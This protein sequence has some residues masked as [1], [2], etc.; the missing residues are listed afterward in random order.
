M[1]GSSEDL[2]ARYRRGASS[3]IESTPEETPEQTEEV[4][5]PVET[6]EVETPE[7]EPEIPEP[8]TEE[9]PEE[10]APAAAKPP[11]T[12][13][14]SVLLAERQK[15]QA[16]AQRAA[17]AE[18]RIRE[19]EAQQRQG[20]QPNIYEDQEAHAKWMADEIDYRVEQKLQADREAQALRNA[21]EEADR[22]FRNLNAAMARYESR[23]ELLTEAFEFAT[24]RS[25]DIAWTKLALSQDDP[26]AFFL[27]EKNRHALVEEIA[28]DP[29]GYVA[30]KIAERSN[31]GTVG[32]P[33]APAPKPQ[34]AA[35]APNSLASARGAASPPTVTP[36]R[37]EAFRRLFNK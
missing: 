32:T 25:N 26:I 12:V 28:R 21:Q 16:E 4:T 11:Q 14:L 3:E 35:T 17:A 34:M 22:E 1:E 15:A 20:N 30:R 7:A 27:E 19:I 2:F 33:V 10:K 31:A 13:P 23:P 37:E 36:S 9:K 29:E 8:T 5:E 18:Q 24:P 6:P